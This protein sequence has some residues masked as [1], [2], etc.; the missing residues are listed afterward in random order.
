MKKLSPF[1]ALLLAVLMP[2][3][4][5]QPAALRILRPKKLL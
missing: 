1:S 3:I 5:F 4:S 2:L